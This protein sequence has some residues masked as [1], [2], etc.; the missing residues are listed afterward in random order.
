MAPL[1]RFLGILVMTAGVLGFILSLSVLIAIWIIQPRLTSSIKST[2]DTVDASITTSKNVLT[3]TEQ[4]LGATVSSVE[5]LSSML[6]T[7]ATTVEDTQPVFDQVNS[8]LGDTLPLT[9]DDVSSSIKGAQDAALVLES[10]LASLQNFQTLVG[11]L[12]G[13]GSL[14]V[15]SPQKTGTEK[16]LSES[17]G[18]LAKNLESLPKSFTDM[19]TNLDN[20]DNNLVLLQTNL[21]T[22]SKSVDT[23]SVNLGEYQAVIGDSQQSMDNLQSIVRNFKKNLPLFTRITMAGLTVFLL[24]LIAVQVVIWSQGLELYRGTTRSFALAE[25]RI[26]ASVIKTDDDKAD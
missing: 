26:A 5:S 7:T 8:M 11:S 13:F 10:S 17:L 9:M 22:M 2:M 21:T 24:W 25:D 23:I 1:R 3:I 15:K 19:S 14:I 20:A 12:P 6:E 16:P 4:A 18:N